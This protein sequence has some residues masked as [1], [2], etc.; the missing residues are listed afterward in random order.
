M[1]KRV[2]AC[3]KHLLSF[4]KVATF[5]GFCMIIL[6]IVN[7][8]IV[9]LI[10]FVVCTSNT[11]DFSIDTF[12]GVIRCALYHCVNIRRLRKW[13]KCPLMKVVCSVGSLLNTRGSSC[14]KPV[15]GPVKDL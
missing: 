5:H 10:L 7:K 8:T 15:L 9:D 12:K 11:V 1:S 6:Q 4:K 3:N 2:S 14:S 13:T